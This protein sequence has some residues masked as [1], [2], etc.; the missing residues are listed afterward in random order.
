MKRILPV[1]GFIFAT[2]AFFGFCDCLITIFRTTGIHDTPTALA[3]VVSLFGFL[4]SL[5]IMGYIIK[6]NININK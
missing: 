2:I 4:A 5:A 3:T 6:S 1:L